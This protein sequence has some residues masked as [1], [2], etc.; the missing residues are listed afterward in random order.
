MELG[1]DKVTGVVKYTDDYE[2]TGFLHVKVVTSPYAHAKI[3]YIEYKN[4]LI[5]PTTIRNVL[6][7]IFYKNIFWYA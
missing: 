7:W 2:A 3:K 4:S 6:S 1:I 5:K